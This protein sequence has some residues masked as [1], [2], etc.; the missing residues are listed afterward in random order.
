MNSKFRVWCLN[1]NEW[2]KDEILINSSGLLFHRNIHG[3]LILLKSETHIVQHF[4]GVYD[5]FKKEIYEGDILKSHQGYLYVVV[6]YSCG[7]FIKPILEDF[8]GYDLDLVHSQ[9]ALG[10]VVGNIFE[11]KELLVGIKKTF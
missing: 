5:R 4:T 8:E 10:A 3:T 9:S 11:N 6:F 2:E 1:N 7:F